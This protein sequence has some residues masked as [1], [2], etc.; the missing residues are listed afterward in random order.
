MRK[1]FLSSLF[2][3][4]IISCQDD[5][6]NDLRASK[7]QYEKNVASFKAKFI[8]GFA[9]EDLELQMS[10]FADS[11]KWVSPSAGGDLLG[12][13]DLKNAANAY[14]AN[15]DEITYTN[16]LYF[17]SPIYNS[18]NDDLAKANSNYIR[19]SGVWNNLHTETGKRVQLK[20]MAVMWFNKDG[21]IHRITDF[22]DVSSIPNQISN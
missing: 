18:Q 21:K 15:F 4:L 7:K 2:L 8:A 1:L 19:T 22:M 20:W 3:L 13:E 17:G 11:L 5:S 16:D 6:S 9:K 14:H 10:L 12:Y